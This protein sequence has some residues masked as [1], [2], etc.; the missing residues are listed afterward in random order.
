MSVDP[1]SLSSESAASI[2]RQMELLRQEL[3]RDV[4]SVSD[5]ARELTDWRHY[6]TTFPALSSLLAGVAGY[7]IVPAPRSNSNDGAVSAAAGPSRQDTRSDSFGRMALQMIATAGLR[8]LVVYASQQM[9]RMLAT[10]GISPSG[11][12]VS[13]D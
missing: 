1:T 12:K 8:T 4:D 6:V 13:D 2:C 5:R 7:L 3:R 9:G 10:E 11:R